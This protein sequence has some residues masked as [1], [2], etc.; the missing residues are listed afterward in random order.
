MILKSNQPNS[1]SPVKLQEDSTEPLK[2]LFEALNSEENYDEAIKNLGD[3]IKENPEVDLDP[4]FI[5][6]PKSF[7]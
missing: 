6:Y 2:E 7:Q 5:T 1:G 4:Y 3:Y